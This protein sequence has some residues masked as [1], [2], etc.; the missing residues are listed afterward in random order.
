MS[1]S[2]AKLLSKLWRALDGDTSDDRLQLFEYVPLCGQTIQWIITM[3]SP[4]D[5]ILQVSMHQLC[6]VRSIWMSFLPFAK[7]IITFSYLWKR[8]LICKSHL[9][10]DLVIF[11]KLWTLWLINKGLPGHTYTYDGDNSVEVRD[12]GSKIGFP[13][14][15]NHRTL[16]YS[17]TFSWSQLP[18][19]SM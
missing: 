8:N 11:N 5:K 14:T 16:A 7:P 6:S 17:D 12:F 9:C 13:Y 3:K 4:S 19:L 1:P 2:N 18:T 15:E 10:C